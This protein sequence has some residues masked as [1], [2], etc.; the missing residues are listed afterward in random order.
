MSMPVDE[1]KAEDSQIVVEV[2]L[3]DDG[4]VEPLRVL[5]HES[6]SRFRD[7]TCGLSRLW[8]NYG[9]EWHLVRLQG[10]ARGSSP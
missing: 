3:V 10:V 7:H 6:V 4:R 1:R 9:Y 2:S 8:V 5:L